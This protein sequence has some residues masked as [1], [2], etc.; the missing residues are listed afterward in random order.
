MVS[1]DEERKCHINEKLD[2]FNLGVKAKEKT[3][4][5]GF[6]KKGLIFDS[7]KEIELCF[8]TFQD[9]ENFRDIYTKIVSKFK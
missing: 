1:Q 8:D 7:N 3:L 2:Q 6:V 9:V 4:F 5:L